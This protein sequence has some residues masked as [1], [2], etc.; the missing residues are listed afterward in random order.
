MPALQMT[1]RAMH[2]DV[3]KPG[4]SG[5]KSAVRW[6]HWILRSCFHV[7]ILSNEI[8]GKRKYN[9]INKYSL[10]SQ[11]QFI[12][13]KIPINWTISCLSRKKK[14]ESSISQKILWLKSELCKATLFLRCY[15]FLRPTAIAQSC[16]P[17]TLRA[18]CPGKMLV[19]LLLRWFDDSVL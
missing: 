2:V 15:I 17:E 1:T 18:R 12:L 9:I 7:N 14:N 5:G 10:P 16:L 13:K 11:S 6:T 19:H 8:W 3:T 4:I